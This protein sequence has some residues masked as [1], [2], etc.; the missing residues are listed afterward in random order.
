[1]TIYR[2]TVLDTP[3]APFTGGVQ[4]ADH[5][6]LG[7][8]DVGVHQTGQQQAAGQV[9]HLGIRVSRAELGEWCPVGDHAVGNGHPGVGL[10]VQHPAGEG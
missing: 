6:H 8:V 7:E 4:R 10:G 1:M 5:P 3:A 9:D 2:G